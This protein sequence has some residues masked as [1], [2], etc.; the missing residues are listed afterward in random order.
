MFFVETSAARRTFRSLFKCRAAH[1]SGLV[2]AVN[3]SLRKISPRRRFQRPTARLSIEQL[4]N[5]FPFDASALR[6][7]TLFD[8]PPAI[9]TANISV[10]ASQPIDAAALAVQ[11]SIRVTG[12]DAIFGSIAPE[13]TIAGVD[14]HSTDDSDAEMTAFPDGSHMLVFAGTLDAQPGIYVRRTLPGGAPD[15]PAAQIVPLEIDT[16]TSFAHAVRVSIL[17]LPNQQAIV[18][19]SDS[20]GLHFQRI[21]ADNSAIGESTDV[22]TDTFAEVLE[23]DS[24]ALADG[25]WGIAWIEMSSGDIQFQRFDGL[26]NQVSGP[27]T[28]VSSSASIR[29]DEFQLLPSS[30]A[31]FGIAWSQQES[32][33]IDGQ[34][35]QFLVAA[36]S[37][38]SWAGTPIEIGSST[39]SPTP[40]IAA[41]SDGRWAVIGTRFTAVE[42][43]PEVRI[44]DAQ[45]GVLAVVALDSGLDVGGQHP[46]ITTLPGLGFA[47]A[48]LDEP[49]LA[50]PQISLQHYTNSG[51]P[52]GS[53]V[54]VNESPLYDSFIGSL[55]GLPDGGVAGYWI[56]TAIDGVSPAILS[57]T[58]QMHLL[59]LHTEIE[60]LDPASNADAVII[61]GVP[62][63]AALSRGVRSSATSWQVDLESLADLQ[64]VS[65]DPLSA[66]TLTATVVDD[67]LT[68]TSLA[69]WAI[70]IGTPD[71][72]QLLQAA[73]ASTVD[74]RGGQ[75]TLV[76][77][78]PRDDYQLQFLNA[79]DIDS[80]VSVQL[81]HGPTDQVQLLVDIEILEFDD[82]IIDLTSFWNETPATDLPLAVA[83]YASPGSVAMRAMA[84]PNAI[85]N[86]PTE[87]LAIGRVEAAVNTIF[88][89]L[90]RS[91]VGEVRG[92]EQSIRNMSEPERVVQAKASASEAK[93]PEAGGE[94]GSAA[95]PA[96]DSHAVPAP[97]DVTPGVAAV[98]EGSGIEDPL[99][100]PTL[101]APQSQPAIAF[102]PLS[103]AG[104]NNPVASIRKLYQNSG[105]VSQPVVPP[106]VAQPEPAAD[107]IAA[108]AV[109]MPFESPV[110]AMPTAF[111]S[112]QLFAKI[113]QVEQEVTLDSEAVE[114]MAGSAVVL[115]SG[116][117]IA[118]VAW[119]LRGSMLLT[120]LMSS[121]P[122]WVSF[123][124]L[125]VLA[126]DWDRC[127]AE[128][129][130]DDESLL[131]I[132]GIQPLER[133][134]D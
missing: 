113:D 59:R 120:K 88:A 45:G 119:L 87:S 122:I 98:K 1:H 68:Q 61:T 50:G 21:N 100:A 74:G 130:R 93:G 25:G 73:A 117:S 46:E 38:G 91:M 7:E 96:A 89:E 37:D 56:G 82:Q 85:A 121:M 17:P 13:T 70:T 72:D 57:R 132:A 33:S 4:E 90:E 23:L 34:Q 10:D 94:S 134:R 2:C 30:Q 18:S 31:A 97:S 40:A 118:Q 32:D 110:L 8:D 131:D 42:S 48:T 54:I 83:W 126:G 109:P 66:I 125:P 28:L 101:S 114:L 44:L 104:F 35:Q 43:F 29:L 49:P 81:V 67:G 12:G 128:M 99:A 20:A 6:P 62:E 103:S 127:A 16:T 92:M 36:A 80:P 3:M 11:P 5:R 47:I 86:K 107:E 51:E 79:D 41:L 124:P 84:M 75:D 27:V 22:F 65:V 26:G 108:A 115:A 52:I 15:G 105:P 102:A 14:V 78:G 77:D 53:A 95:H 63:S 60:H 123:D 24:I 69:S 71:D 76:V 133:S 64:L 116:F 9:S 19:W 112:Q 58:M 55:V 129:N 106:V 111:D 39:F